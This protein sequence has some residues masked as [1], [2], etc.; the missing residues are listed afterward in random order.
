MNLPKSVTFHPY[1]PAAW[2]RVS[3][4]DA[5]T[6]TRASS[7]MMS[8]AS[9]PNRAVYGLW[10][11][12]KGKTIAD[13]FILAGRTADE[14]WIGSYF[15]P[16]EAIRR[17]LEDLIVADDVVIADETPGWAGN[18][19]RSGRGPGRGCRRLRWRME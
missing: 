7:P 9:E 14:F 10:L 5:A 15:C 3:G 11:D 17:R 16:A 1:R 2:L 4:A 18:Q 12:H 6:F 8:G 13:S 19:P